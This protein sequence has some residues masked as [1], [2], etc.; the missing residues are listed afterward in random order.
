MNIKSDEF[1]P[2]IVGVNKTT[3]G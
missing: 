1:K 2:T 3:S